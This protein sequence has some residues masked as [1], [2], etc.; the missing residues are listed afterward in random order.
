[1][2]FD[3]SRRYGRV[4]R[5]FHWGMTV[6][7]FWQLLKIFDRIDDGEHWVGQTL[8]SWHI[9]IGSLLLVAI[10]ARLVWVAVQPARPAQAG[11]TAGWARLGHGLLFAGMLLMPVTGVLSMVG[12]GY[13]WAPFGLQIVPRGEEVEWMITVGS[14]H[15]PIAWAL[16]ILILGHI[17]AALLHHF[18][19]NDDSLKR[20]V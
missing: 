17:A 1:M 19:W 13:G 15:S 4:T 7:I 5:L 9:W 8:V 10:V 20:I 18:V 3:S 14:F 6:L 16:L 11:A 12:R 2:W